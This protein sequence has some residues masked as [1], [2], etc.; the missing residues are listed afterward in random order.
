MSPAPSFPTSAGN[1]TLQNREFD[2]VSKLFTKDF[3]DALEALMKDPLETVSTRVRAWYKR[4]AWGNRSLYCVNDDGSPA[5]QADCARQL[6][7]SKQRVHDAI[8]YDRLRGYLNVVGTAKVLYPV[9]SPELRK[10]E[11]DPGDD[12][13]TS[14]K[15]FQALW[16]SAHS[17]EDAAWKAAQA[18]VARIRCQVLEEYRE[19]KKSGA[20]SGVVKKSG[21]PR[22]EPETAPES[23]PVK[24]SG[25]P[26]TPP[27]STNGHQKS[28]N[29]PDSQ[30]PPGALAPTRR[31]EIDL[32][33]SCASR[34]ARLDFTGAKKILLD[35]RSIAPE[36]TVDDITRVIDI[37]GPQAARAERS[38][39]GFLIRAVPDY[40][41]D[42]DWSVLLRL[43]PPI[44]PSS[45]RKSKTD[46]VNE[47]MRENMRKYG[48]PWG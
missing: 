13:G 6:D 17:A 43:P 47:L 1:R 8:T 9:V 30:P 44:P 28:P 10:P 41:R 31:D 46:E 22:T 34:Y 45:Q 27:E 18:T 42:G 36:I 14:F 5:F 40:F 35:C 19:S 25:T 39:S 7:I 16:L 15:S 29:V 26:R 4:K 32:I 12:S 38:P 20:E 24:K 11:P 21:T 3:N 23:G 2:A 37:K 33:V 48:T